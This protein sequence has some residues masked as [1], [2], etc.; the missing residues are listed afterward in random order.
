M[1]EDPQMHGSFLVPIILGIDKTT[2]SVAMG[3][4]EYWPCICPLAIFKIMFVKL[5]VMVWF[6]LDF[7]QLQKVSFRNLIYE[8]TWSN[9]SFLQPKHNLQKM[10]NFRNFGANFIIP[11]LCRF[12]HLSVRECTHQSSSNAVMVIFAMPSIF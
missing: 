5:I 10:A 12:C 2:V 9:T 3:D 4:N 1:A 11:L 8:K 7:L 6:F